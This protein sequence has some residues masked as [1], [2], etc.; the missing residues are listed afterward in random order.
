[1]PS[2]SLAEWASGTSSKEAVSPESID[3]YANLLPAQAS[4]PPFRQPGAARQTFVLLAS[5]A[6]ASTSPGTPRRCRLLA[7]EDGDELICSDACGSSEHAL[8][9]V[10]M[11]VFHDLTYS[12]WHVPGCRELPPGG[13]RAHG[14][15]C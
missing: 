7:L 12:F 13:G 9:N 14:L 15:G 5:S 11:S 3:P 4:E 1:M 8:I 10:F 2:Q 6:A